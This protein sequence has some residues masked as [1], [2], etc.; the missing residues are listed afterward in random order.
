M[1]AM[2]QATSEG[3]ERAGRCPCKVEV[4]DDWKKANVAPI[5]KEAKRTIQETAGSAILTSVPAEIMG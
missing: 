1:Q 5:F 2:K 3:A 4:S